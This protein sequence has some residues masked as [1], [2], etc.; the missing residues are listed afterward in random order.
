MDAK[1]SMMSVSLLVLMISLVSLAPAASAFQFESGTYYYTGDYFKE[2]FGDVK[3][4]PDAVLKDS[5]VYV[6][7]NAFYKKFGMTPKQA[8]P[9][10]EE[11]PIE[12][13][14]TPSAEVEADVPN[15]EAPEIVVVPVAAPPEENGTDIV[16]AVGEEPAAPE[17]PAPPVVISNEEFG[18][19]NEPATNDSN[20]SISPT[21]A[22][23]SGGVPVQLMVI[24]FL[25]VVIIIMLAVLLTREEK[26]SNGK[27]GKAKAD[28]KKPE[29]KSKE[30]KKEPKKEQK[31]TK[32]VESKK[33]KDWEEGT[34]FKEAKEKREAKDKAK[35][36]QAKSESV[37]PEPK[38]ASKGEVKPF[39]LKI[40][41]ES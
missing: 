37:K 16:P 11:L 27:S 33:S 18:V 31:D 36:V 5:M 21:P 2:N 17:L 8:P 41:D 28:V 26:S 12:P 38:A 6:D 35:A 4:V 10:V 34:F 15:E 7:S 40:K 29:K 23:V 39:L 9:S 24:G 22:A 3:K 30:L 32:T 20:A 13:E 25:I 14:T 1:K 19:E